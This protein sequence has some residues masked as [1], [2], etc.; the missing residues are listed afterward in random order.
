MRISFK[1]LF[2]PLPF[3][4]SLLTLKA[5]C[6][7]HKSLHGISTWASNR[8]GQIEISSGLTEAKTREAWEIASFQGRRCARLLAFLLEGEAFG[9]W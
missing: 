9:D 1:E 3:P 7:V 4:T 8:V 6:Q 2:L 5:T